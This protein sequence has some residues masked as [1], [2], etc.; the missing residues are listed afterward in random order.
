MHAVHVHC[1]VAVNAAKQCQQYCSILRMN[2]IPDSQGVGAVLILLLYGVEWK[3]QD[4]S[5]CIAV[6]AK[7]S[8]WKCNMLTISQTNVHLN[9]LA[10]WSC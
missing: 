10:D 4:Q 6:D 5:A 9:L 3:C 8:D 1:E 7:A 2:N